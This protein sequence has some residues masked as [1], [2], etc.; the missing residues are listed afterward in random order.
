MA[1]IFVH[2]YP[3][4]PVVK[5]LICDG[6]T[7]TID[8]PVGKQQQIK[9][10]IQELPGKAPKGNYHVSGS[11]PLNNQY[12]PSGA[13][14]T[15]ETDLIL[16]CDPMDK[17]NKNNMRFLRAKWNP[18]KTDP[19][20][21]RAALCSV[22]PWLF[23]E[24]MFNGTVTQIDLTVDVEGVRCDDLYFHYPKS[25]ITEVR[26]ASGRTEYIGGEK[27]PIR[28]RLYD[29]K[30]QV[31]QK[32]K[33][34]AKPLQ[35]SVPEQE[36]T[37]I[38][39]V[40]KPYC[41]LFELLAMP[42]PFVKLTIAAHNNLIVHN[43]PCWGFFLDSCQLRGASSALQKIS[44][45]DLHGKFKARLLKGQAEWWNPENVWA[46]LPAVLAKIANIP[47]PEDHAA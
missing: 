1:V 8:V 31:K 22:A 35:E 20:E 41:K 10:C 3:S 18:A 39:L 34:K 30:A 46:Q 7:M 4:V 23:D 2:K 6:L 42:S 17:Y 19:L 27:S 37:R 44:G 14:K 47:V 12:L 13:D 33:G 45:S 26:T 29:K 9:K 28:W 21:V 15:G 40:K 11:L 38:E 25:T 24:L 16:Q 5:A 43:E 32:N 36:V